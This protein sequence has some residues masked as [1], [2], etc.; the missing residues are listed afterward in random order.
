M[1][2]DKRKLDIIRAKRKIGVNRLAKKAGVGGSTI[3]AG[4]ERNIDPV[5]IG[6]IAMALEVNV[7]DI[8]TNEDW[9]A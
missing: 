6:K 2:L 5:S 3:Y 9:E 7:E 8:I 1:K 4:Y